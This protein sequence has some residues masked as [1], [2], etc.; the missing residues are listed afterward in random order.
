MWGFVCAVVCLMI[1]FWNTRGCSRR[2]CRLLSHLIEMGWEA[3]DNILW[4]EQCND[5]FA[6]VALCC[7]FFD[8]KELFLF[9][10][11]R[12]DRL[13][14]QMARCQGPFCVKSQS[15]FKPGHDSWC[16]PRKYMVMSAN[17]AS[18]IIPI[19]RASNGTIT[20]V[21]GKCN[22]FHCCWWW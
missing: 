22:H 8:R 2:W 7:A 18:Q 21:V 17:R 1:L 10:D 20:T 6:V 9:V 11:W 13:N 19:F 15:D 3:L 12:R 14:E 4:W 16:L 5:L